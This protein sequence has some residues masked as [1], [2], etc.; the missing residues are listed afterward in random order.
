[1]A[2]PVAR[3]RK[4]QIAHLLRA[5]AAITGH[6]LFV[7]VGTGAVIAQAKVIAL[8]LTMTREIDIYAAD[9]DDPDRLSDLIDGS[10][11]EGSPFD[12]A[13][14]YYAHGVFERTACLPEDWRNRAVR[15]DVPGVE[16]TACLCPEVNDI[17]VSKLCAWRDKDLAW[18]DAGLTSGLLDLAVMR[19]RAVAIANPN[20]PDAV[21]M[22][23]SSNG[24]DTHSK[25][26]K[27][28]SDLDFATQDEFGRLVSAAAEI[29]GAVRRFEHTR[30]ASQKRNQHAGVEITLRPASSSRTAL[31]NVPASV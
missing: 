19:T 26:I 8:D 11:G 17:A 15:I 5:A 4:P 10:I 16:G 27:Q 12:E 3:L 21:E 14:G 18:L 13:F 23:G 24:F 1:M 22:A 2:K 9:T 20:V 7:M 29:V 30:G 6:D 28:V 25:T 31:A